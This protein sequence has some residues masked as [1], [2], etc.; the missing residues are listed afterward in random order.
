MTEFVHTLK[1][2]FSGTDNVTEK[3]VQ[4]LVVVVLLLLINRLLLNAF[5][6]HFEDGTKV[7]R[8]RR[9]TKTTSIIVL[10]VMI[11]VIW[12]S[13]SSNLFDYLSYIAIA[14]IVV[15][16]ETISNIAGGLIIM[17]RKPFVLGDRIEI[18]NYKGDIVNIDVVYTT[19]VE[20]GGDRVNGEQ[21]TGRIVHIP[22]SKLLQQAI[23]NYNQG[24]EYVWMEIPITVTFE[25]DWQKAKKIIEE[26][27]VELTGQ[28]AKEA[29]KD[30]RKASREFYF[31]PGKLT[32]IIYTKTIDYGITLTARFIVGPR[33]MRGVESAF[34]ER[35]L[36]L[37][38]DHAD[39]SLAYPTTRFYSKN[40]ET[41]QIS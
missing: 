36:T 18:E 33:A 22:N 31:K 40:E 21:S 29:Q 37:F 9:T 6:R 4:T 14:I 38:K 12:L 20:V 5:D 32:P 17:A 13:D 41:Q 11:I 28:F 16:H 39:I 3:I 15:L 23:A 27:T 30:F 25:S 26:L 35:L 19:I 10:V 24:F 34:S 2:I 1:A 8:L 7:Y